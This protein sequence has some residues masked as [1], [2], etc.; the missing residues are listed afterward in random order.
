VSLLAILLLPPVKIVSG[1]GVRLASTKKVTVCII[2]TGAERK[3][4]RNGQES[5]VVVRG[6]S[7][8]LVVVEALI[9]ESAFE[10][11]KW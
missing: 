11:V 8:P 1:I 7:H 4:E 2:S 5:G 9:A 3:G 6:G 10:L